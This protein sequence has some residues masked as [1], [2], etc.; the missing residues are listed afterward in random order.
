MTLAAE[1]STDTRDMLVVHTAI[2]REFRLAPGLVLGVAEGD[3]E[4]SAVVAEHVA[5]LLRLLHHHHQ[6][7]DRLIWPLMLERL[8]EDLAP[9]VHT[10]ESQHAGISASIEQVEEA[11]PAWRSS[12]AAGLGEDLAARLEAMRTL[13]EEHLALE[14]RELLPLAA[15]ALSQQEWDRLGEEGMASLDKKD[16]S[17]AL[18]MFM[19]EGDPA[20][21]KTMLSHA[22]L[23]PRLLLPHLAPAAYRRYARR[24]Y[25]TTTP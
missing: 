13:L 3:T 25:G 21:I 23:L 8:P 14:E 7:E 11:L 10:M 20:V 15:R 6:G 22:P 4:R 2:R 16:A 12:A 24:V 18:G 9:I 17:L 19:Y 1:G 5:D